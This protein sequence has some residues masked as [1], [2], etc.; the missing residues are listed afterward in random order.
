V[1]SILF[2]I[3]FPVFG[4]PHNQALR[5]AEPLSAR[6][7]ETIVVVPAEAADAVERLQEAGVDVRP[8][9]LHRLRATRDPRALLRLA[10]SAPREIAHL[11]TL[12][13]SERIGIVQIGGLVNPHA[14]IAA[15]LEGVP[16]VWQL[17]DT[18]APR[19][20]AAAAMVWVRRL[21]DVV[22]STGFGVARAHPG[23]AGIADRVIAFF[24]PVD[25][26]RFAPRPELKAEVR[27]EW[28]LSPSDLVVGSIANINPQKGVVELIQAFGEARLR[29]PDSR[30]VLVGAEYA[31]HRAYSAAVRMQLATEG[32]VEG[33]DVVFTGERHDV[34][35]QMAGMDVM[36]LAAVPRSEGITTAI[37]EGM[38]AGLPVV[39][40]D[41][42]ALREAVDDGRTGFVV[43]PQ[44]TSAFADALARLL[45]DA[46]LRSRMGAEARRVAAER[47][48]ID[49]CAQR[50]VEAYTQALARHSKATLE[51]PATP[52]ARAAPAATVDGI[53]IYL[54]SLDSSAHDELD[55]AHGHNHKAAQASHYDRAA[56]EAFEIDRPHKSPRLYRFLLAQKFRRAVGPIGR[57][58]IGATALTVCGGS[59]MDADY[60]ARAGAA[61]TSSDLSVGA[62]RRAKAR[63]ERHGIAF[64]S[65]VADV[66]HLPYPD[67]SFDLVMVHDGLHHLDDPYAGLSEMMRVAR[68]WVVVTE[69]AQASI[70]RVAVRLG[71]ALETEEAGNR[72]A[73]MQPSEVRDYLQARGYSVIR[74]ERYAMYY[75]HRPGVVFALLSRPVIFPVVRVG[76]QAA[77][78]LFGRFGN[79]MVVVAQRDHAV[80]A[81]Q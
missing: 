66:E 76:W 77:N 3:H 58:L 28:G 27:S 48:G 56:E 73:R 70:T 42:G 51:A 64:Q 23:Y 8:I 72:V 74:A 55:H 1:I 33:R 4:G 38:A 32:L 15:R 78:A 6:G 39:V 24:P 75:P 45:G 26:A 34:E 16:V 65:I 20:V 49:V 68:R 40:T 29:R 47:F 52:E 43:P 62:A 59:G 2:V 41:V 31:S 71:L 57:D 69:P 11:R 19:P 5:L 67:R 50:H 63:S 36:A 61:V 25:L 30:L 13:R 37:L 7:F 44:E 60:L 46:A 12:I 9:G 18:R 54:S 53:P 14:A 79:K 81:P 35:R 21:A 17:L 22:M 80:E 10:A